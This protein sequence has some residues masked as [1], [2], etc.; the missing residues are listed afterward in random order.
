MA[1]TDVQSL[2]FVCAVNT[3]VANFRVGENGIKTVSKSISPS[4]LHFFSHTVGRMT[5]VLAADIQYV[6]VQTQDV[7]E[8]AHLHIQQI[9]L[10]FFTMT[11]IRHF[12]V[13]SNSR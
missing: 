12:W 7:L 10:A 3:S 8:G 11:N 13:A 1:E 4:S 2:I 6:L 9:Q 5:D